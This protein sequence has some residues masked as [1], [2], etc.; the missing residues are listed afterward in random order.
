[1][2]ETPKLPNESPKKVTLMK[3]SRHK[4]DRTSKL[5][6]LTSAS[7]LPAEICGAE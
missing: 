7:A 3:L 6:V 5:L 4:F 2:R 1:M